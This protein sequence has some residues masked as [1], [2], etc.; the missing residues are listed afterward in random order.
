[1][2]VIGYC[3]ECDE[4]IDKRRL[5]IIPFALCCIECQKKIGEEE[6]IKTVIRHQQFID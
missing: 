1:V 3:E 4:K 2:E 5:E 6:K